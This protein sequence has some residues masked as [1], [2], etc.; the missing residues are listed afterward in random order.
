MVIM[1]SISIFVNL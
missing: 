1:T